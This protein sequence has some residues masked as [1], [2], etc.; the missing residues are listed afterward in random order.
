LFSQLDRISPVTTISTKDLTTGRI[1]I[2]KESCSFSSF[3]S[4]GAVLS[5]PAI[6]ED[7]TIYCG[8]HVSSRYAGRLYALY[9]NGTLRWQY[10]TSHWVRVGPCIGDNGTIYCVS[11]DEYLH[12]LYPNGTL[13]WKTNVGAGTYP[14]IGP[15]GTIYAG[16]E[17]LHAI[18]PNNG[19]IKWKFNPGY[20]KVIEGGAPITSAD[21]TIYFG[22]RIL[23]LAGGEIIALYSNGTEKWR[24]KICDTFID[25]SLAIGK[26]G[27]VYIGSTSEGG[28]HL[29][30]FG[31]VESNSPPETPTISG[32]TNGEAGKR[33]WYRFIADDP[34]NNPIRFY[35]D[36]GD[37]NEGWKGE[38]APRQHCYYE[39]TWS[40]QDSYTIRAKVKDV[41]GEESDW[42]YLEVTMPVNQPVQ[43]PL[44]ELFRERFPLLYQI[45]SNVLEELNI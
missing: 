32:E 34:D 35:I 6:G 43:Y 8:C 12:A 41:L 19:T 44:L 26:D 45:L 18:Y 38:R 31:P 29:H 10:N 1:G 16:F 21:G 42:A 7:G 13:K 37:G 20:R 30:A 9:P 5:S 36:W 39:H 17:K 40:T 24:K 3:F 4:I 25:S 11:L 14:T 2:S 22:T 23:E 27:T 28:G 33:Y 15:D